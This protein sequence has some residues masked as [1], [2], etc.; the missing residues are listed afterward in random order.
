MLELVQKLGDR[1]LGKVVPEVPAAAH[2]FCGCWPDEAGRR[3]HFYKDCVSCLC[4]QV[5]TRC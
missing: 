5:S 2:E 1:L 3:W 4:Y